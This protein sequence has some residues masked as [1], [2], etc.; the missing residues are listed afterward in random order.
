[1][2]S[3]TAL[4]GSLALVGVAGLFWFLLGKKAQAADPGRATPIYV[5]PGW[6][7]PYGQPQAYYAPTGPVQL[8]GPLVAF[9]GQRYR[10][11]VEVNF[12]ASLAAD[13]DNVQAKA[14]QAGFQNVHVAR[15]AKRPVDW[16]GAIEGDYYVTG[17]YTGQ[18]KTLERSYGGGQVKILDVW[19]G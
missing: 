6:D 7:R 5:P 3:L 1:M 14:M 19:A 10:A 16:P 4:Q 17:V 15:K 9:P 18:Q 8:T 2:K 13:V 12:P 11:T